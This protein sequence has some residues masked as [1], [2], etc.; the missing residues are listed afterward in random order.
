MTSNQASFIKYLSKALQSITHRLSV[1]SRSALRSGDW[2]ILIPVSVTVLAV[3]THRVAGANS[4][5]FVHDSVEDQISGRPV[6]LDLILEDSTLHRAEL[7]L[8]TPR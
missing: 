6:D 4:S 8:L 2:D 1:Q 3:V 7:S 5:K